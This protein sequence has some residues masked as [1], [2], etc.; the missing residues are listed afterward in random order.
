[1]LE[2]AK[3]FDFDPS[4]TKQVRNVVP[5]S[6]SPDLGRIWYAFAIDF[7]LESL[8]LAVL[9]EI[10]PRIAE[11][12]EWKRHFGYDVMS[13]LVHELILYADPVFVF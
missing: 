9:D 11:L 7:Y 6:F 5:A 13:G 4:L 12:G 8:E 1:M 2:V 10:F 3:R